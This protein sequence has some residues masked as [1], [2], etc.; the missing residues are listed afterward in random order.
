MIDRLKFRAWYYDKDDENDLNNNKMFYNAQDTY[1][2]L[3]GYPPIP[4]SSFGDM[5]DDERWIVEQCIGLKD[6]NDKL[7]YENDIVKVSGIYESGIYKIEFCQSDCAYNLYN[8]EGDFV[9]QLTEDITRYM[10]VI[11]NIH[12]NADLLEYK[13]D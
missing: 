8:A 5:L 13:N 2:Y 4:E 1:D 6:K 3:C 7:I 11:G 10:E 9:Y 12:E